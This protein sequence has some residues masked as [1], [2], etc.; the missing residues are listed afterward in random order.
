MYQICK[1]APA[2]ISDETPSSVIAP[3]SE[4]SE[5][6]FFKMKFSVWLLDFTPLSAYNINSYRLRYMETGSSR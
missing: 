6:V 5:R 4:V 1:I 2:A 3:F